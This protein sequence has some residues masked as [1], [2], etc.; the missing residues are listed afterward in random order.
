MS[1]TE[2]R[3]MAFKLIYSLEV[4]SVENLEDQ[5]NIYIENEQIF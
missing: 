1:R 5:I 2:I 4:Q 3:D